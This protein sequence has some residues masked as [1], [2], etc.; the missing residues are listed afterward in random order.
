MDG[1]RHLRRRAAA[2]AAAIGLV[3][4]L[5]GAAVAD[6]YSYHRTAR[7]DATAAAIAVKGTDLPAAFRLAGGRVK[8]DESASTDTC[9]GYSPKE[10]DL[11]VTGDAA[12]RY[13]NKAAGVLAVYSEVQ[14]MKTTAMAATDVSRGVRMLSRTCSMQ[15]VKSEHLELVSYKSLGRATCACDFSDS[16][17]FETATKSSAINTLWVF[18]VMRHGRIEASVITAVGKSSTDTRNIALGAALGLQGL[19]VK[20]IS[21]RFAAA[22]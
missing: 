5:C 15:Q 6:N 20:A 13:S 16:I 9:N 3:L 17:T 14:L 7:D 1:G 2:S 10:S 11:V 8:P 21:G 18:T 19:A 4:A 22:H 12:T